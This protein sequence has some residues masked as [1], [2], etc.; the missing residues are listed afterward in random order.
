MSCFLGIEQSC[1]ECGLCQDKKRSVR[2]ISE[3][4]VI[5]NENT[6]IL[7]YGFTECC[8]YD[9]GLKGFGNFKVKFCPL[10]G[11]RIIA[12]EGGVNEQKRDN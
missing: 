5:T 1:D 3:K 9:F 11:K 8:G 10:C 12:K 6:T 7:I 4:N 2:K